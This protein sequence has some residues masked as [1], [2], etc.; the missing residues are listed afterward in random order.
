LPKSRGSSCARTR[1]SPPS[2][3][4]TSRIWAS[5]YMRA[6]HST[7]SHR[8]Q[9]RAPTSKHLNTCTPLF[10]HQNAHLYRA[11]CLMQRCRCARV[12]CHHVVVSVIRLRWVAARVDALIWRRAKSDPTQQGICAHEQLTNFRADNPHLQFTRQPRDTNTR[13][14]RNAGHRCGRLRAVL[15][16]TL[17]VRET[18]PR[19]MCACAGHDADGARHKARLDRLPCTRTSSRASS[20][21]AA[22]HA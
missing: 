16:E 9:S 13:A 21:A 1:A 14:A 4:H 8:Q 10:S 20:P 5:P 2:P 7:F 18:F 17:N 15:V 22:H 19:G 11:A 6:R 3:T 12:V